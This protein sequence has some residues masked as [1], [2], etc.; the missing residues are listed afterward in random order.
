M[1]KNTRNQWV[2]GRGLDDLAGSS[3]HSYPI[4]WPF[5]STLKVKKLRHREIPCCPP[6]K[7]KG[8]TLG[9]SSSLL[10]LHPCFWSGIARTLSFLYSLSQGVMS[11]MVVC[12]LTVNALLF[13]R[14]KERA[15]EREDVSLRLA[16]GSEAG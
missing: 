4:G 2:K 6:W 8:R 14:E 10:M 16:P 13:Y 11:R 15:R 12:L 3:Q 1:K 5:V 9:S 7:D